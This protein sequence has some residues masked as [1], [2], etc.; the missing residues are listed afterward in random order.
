MMEEAGTASARAAVLIVEDND[1]LRD[2]EVEVLT[3]EGHDVI[4]VPNGL[5]ALMVLAEVKPK[6][7]LLDLMLPVVSGWQ[8]L[9][10]LRANP[11]LSDIPVVVISA[12]AEDAL[13]NV[14]PVLH[15]P[16]SIDDLKSAV[17]R[18]SR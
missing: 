3:G 2:L 7:I 12:C 11:A 6:L 4:A 8:V 5:Q 15:K 1:D 9:A 14:V 13:R 17:R 16:I 10:E 18:Y